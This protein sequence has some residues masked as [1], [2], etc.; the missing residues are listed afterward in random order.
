MSTIAPAEK[1]CSGCGRLLPLRLFRFRKRELND[2]HAECGSCHNE[3]MK[4]RTAKTR[5]TDLNQLLM[6]VNRNGGLRRYRRVEALATAA[7][8]RFG[9]LDRLVRLWREVTEQAHDQGKPHVAVRSLEALGHL[10]TVAAKS[11]EAAAQETR[12]ELAQMSDA[13]LHEAELRAVRLAIREQPELAVAAAL[14]LGWTVVP[15]EDCGDSQAGNVD[16]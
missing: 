16:G 10:L 7:I 14:E 9:G 11:Q 13:E 2:R 3:R 5:Q 15:P 1:I 6:D 12:D 8:A 4:R